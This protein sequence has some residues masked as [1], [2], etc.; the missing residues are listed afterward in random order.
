MTRREIIHMR[1]MREVREWVQVRMRGWSSNRVYECVPKRQFAQTAASHFAG[2][3]SIRDQRLNR[4]YEQ[5]MEKYFA[6]HKQ[7]R[8]QAASSI[9]R[10]FFYLCQFF[11]ILFNL[12]NNFY[13]YKT[14]YRKIITIN[15]YKILYIYI[16][17][18]IYYIK[19][20][21]SLA[22]DCERV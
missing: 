7:D 22:I 4:M 1:G 9:S 8:W 20:N 2:G 18:Y 11:F 12:F 17:I 13:Y 6:Y 16:Y 19:V 3:R 15:Y 10:N 5:S 21:I 14:D